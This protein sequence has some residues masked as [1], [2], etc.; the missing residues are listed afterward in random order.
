MTAISISRHQVESGKTAGIAADK[1]TDSSLR[2]YMAATKPAA[3]RHKVD[4]QALLQFVRKCV[5]FK[6]RIL[7]AI[8][9]NAV[10]RL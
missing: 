3:E 6:V 5:L 9:F 2:I 8:K 1:N 10:T 4:K 7:I